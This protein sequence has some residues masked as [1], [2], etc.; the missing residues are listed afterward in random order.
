MRIKSIITILQLKKEHLIEFKIWN[1]DLNIW[2]IQPC[3]ELKTSDIA[4]LDP[5]K[6]I[7]FNH[8]NIFIKYRLLIVPVILW[9][10]LGIADP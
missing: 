2:I 5:I 10:I 7:S 4:V 1:V 3:D 6:M 9:V 8:R